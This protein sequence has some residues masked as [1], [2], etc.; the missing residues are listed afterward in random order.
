MDFGL[1]KFNLFLQSA[2]DM[3]FEIHQTYISLVQYVTEAPQ[4]IK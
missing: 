3:T 2:V 4:Y 1:K